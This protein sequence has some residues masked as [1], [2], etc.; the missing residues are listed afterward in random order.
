MIGG[1]TAEEDILGGNQIIIVNNRTP[2]NTVVV[3]RLPP[4][5]TLRLLSIEGA[6]VI[7]VTCNRC[8]TIDYVD[9]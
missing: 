3:F 5:A 9:C 6:I 7:R 8:F 1:K 2:N 4:V